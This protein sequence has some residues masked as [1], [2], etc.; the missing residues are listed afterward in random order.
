MAALA[1]AAREGA[2]ALLT[3]RGFAL[4]SVGISGGRGGKILRFTVDRQGDSQAGGG[5]WRGSGVTLDDC[6]ELS[7]ALSALLDG[8]W[9]DDGP[10]YVLEV[11][12]PGLDRPVL[13]E[14]DLLRFTGSLAKLRLRREGRTLTLA[15]RLRCSPGSFA[16]VPEAS[17]AKPG[18]PR[19]APEPAAFEWGEVI[20]ARLVPEF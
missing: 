16:I 17:P 20:R 3:E 6:A 9:P 19:Q 18:K 14:E 2:S 12:S 4:C 15:G 5:P 7:K 11:S 10:G 8:L 1:A 13:S